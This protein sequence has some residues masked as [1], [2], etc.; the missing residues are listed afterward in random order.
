[1]T[2]DARVADAV[3]D[4][5]VVRCEETGVAFS[6]FCRRYNN[7]RSCIFFLFAH[8][9]HFHYLFGRKRGEIP[10]RHHTHSTLQRTRPSHTIMVTW[11]RHTHTPDTADTRGPGGQHAAA[12]LLYPLY[13]HSSRPHSRF[14]TLYLH[15]ATQYSQSHTHRTLVSSTHQHIQH[16]TSLCI[17]DA[18]GALGGRA[19]GTVRCKSKLKLRDI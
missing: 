16:N 10:P 17:D 4:R 9:L 18:N 5:L 6:H 3:G 8:F 13:Q 2:V 15:T 11:S 12:L 7:A 1:M 19:P 14:G